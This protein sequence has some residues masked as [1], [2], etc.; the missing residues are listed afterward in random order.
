MWC[1]VLFTVCLKRRITVKHQ[2]QMI[3]YENEL[4][5]QSEDTSMIKCDEQRKKLF[6]EIPVL[7]LNPVTLIDAICATVC[8]L[9][10]QNHKSDQMSLCSNCHLERISDQRF[11]IQRFIK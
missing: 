10:C 9:Y 11:R 3:T 2:A 7:L 4:C 5:V 8:T 6:Q 1:N